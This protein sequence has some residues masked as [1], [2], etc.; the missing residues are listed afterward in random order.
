MAAA[1]AAA[2]AAAQMGQDV[3]LTAHLPVLLSDRYPTYQRWIMAFNN[4]V[5]C[6]LPLQAARALAV[7]VPFANY[8]AAQRQSNSRCKLV[9][10]ECLG[11]ED[12]DLI[13]GNPRF[14]VNMLLL[15]TVYVA[16]NASDVELLQVQLVNLVMEPD[17]RLKSYL[18]PRD[19]NPEATLGSERSHQRR[20][21]DHVVSGRATSS[22]EEFQNHRQ[23]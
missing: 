12:W 5:D 10:Q 1:A 16:V 20:H 22:L 15:Q 11:A 8:T 2:A 14:C 3:K 6:F 4:Y 13:A 17:E 9:L 19:I 18:V 23:T 7:N 21:P